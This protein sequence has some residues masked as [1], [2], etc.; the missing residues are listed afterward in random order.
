MNH[1]SFTY[2]LLV[3]LFF[4]PHAV[5]FAQSLPTPNIIEVK[6]DDRVATIYWNSKTQTYSTAYD[7]DKQAGISSYL[8][9]WGKESEGFTNSTVTPYRAHM[10]QPLEPGFRYVARVYNLDNYGHKSAPS[11]TVTFAH[12]D[13]RVNAMRTRLNGFFDDMNY[14]MGAF[15]EEDWNQAYSACTAQPKLSQHINSQFHGHNVVA[16]GH[17]DRGIASSRLRHPFDFSGRTGTIEFDLDGSQKARQFW[18]LDLTPFSRK[19]DLGGHVSLNSTAP[20]QADPPHMLRILERGEKIFV[21]LADADGNLQNLP[22][23]YRN[24]ACGNLLTYCPGENLVPLINVRRHWKI[25]LSKTEIKI[26]INDI[27]VV[28]CSLISTDSPNGL[29]YEV[30]QI[31]WILFSYNTTKENILLSMIHWDNFGI[32]APTGYAPSTKIHNYTDGQL[33]SESGRTGN[34]PSVGMTASLSTP[35][36][37][38]IPIPDPIVDLNGDQPLKAELMFTIQGGDYSWT[39]DDSIQVNGHTYMLPKPSSSI[40]GF[41]DEDL[42]NSIRPHSVVLP[43][44][45]QDLISGNNEIKFFLSNPRLLNIHIE[46]S[47]P[48]GLA[49]TYSPPSLIYPDHGM[50][51]MGFQTPAATVGPGIV[52]NEIAGIPFWQSEFQEEHNPRAGIE[53]QYVKQSPV[54][55][56][57]A[58]SIGANSVAQLAATGKAKGI[59]Y[60]EIWIDSIP[61]KTVWVNQEQAIAGFQHEFKINL[62]DIPNGKHELF[63]QA[64]DVEGNASQFDA[65]LAHALPG[66]YIPVIIDIQNNVSLAVEYTYFNAYEYRGEVA[67]RWETQ[68]EINSDYFLI[69]R[70]LDGQLFQKIGKVPAKGTESQYAYIDDTSPKGKLYY[71]LKE[72]EF[73]GNY[74]YSEVRTLRLSDKLSFEVFPNPAKEFVELRISVPGTESYAIALTDLTGRLMQ[75]KKIATNPQQNAIYRF[76]ME[77]LS[78][79]VY[80]VS[81]RTENKVL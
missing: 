26:F 71:R 65:F 68:E 40:P 8:I 35:G 18:Y 62:N 17:C 29:S 16:S 2:S 66:E 48:V 10:I 15:P 78:R 49:P 47:F 28:D 52:F 41:A 25:E 27:L 50:K 80:V 33:G 60:Y 21:Q 58:L 30:A 38:N 12:D 31:N 77:D 20:A 7:P 32:D 13:T 45:P 19:R 72:V 4:A 54:S 6:E 63:I 9:E 22:N 46:L 69:E 39:T 74:S 76:E 70:S 53:L 79:G 24:N 57:L 59:A 42:I 61:V 11:A 67:L 43:I 1:C 14:P 64:Y 37:S 81:L 23:L 44:D 36:V 56:S 51:L 55:D 5:L 73:D 75:S 34:E 3:I